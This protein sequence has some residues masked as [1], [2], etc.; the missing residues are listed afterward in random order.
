MQLM[1]KTWP[2]FSKQGPNFDFAL[3]QQLSLGLSVC[4]TDQRVLIGWP[5]QS[6]YARRVTASR[7]SIRF[8]LNAYD[9]GVYA[10]S[11]AERARC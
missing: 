4:Y 8:P 11:C 5:L 7:G 9:D 1:R 3:Y 6:K 10:D 2:R